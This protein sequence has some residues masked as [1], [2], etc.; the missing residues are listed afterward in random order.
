M[1]PRIHKI[2]PLKPE[3]RV[4]VLTVSARIFFF[5]FAFDYSIRITHRNRKSICLLL[6]IFKIEH[7]S[8]LIS[9]KVYLSVS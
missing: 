3:K 9:E 1:N 6:L 7:C 8:V 4:I 2:Y 5:F